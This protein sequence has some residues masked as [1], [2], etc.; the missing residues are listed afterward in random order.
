MIYS[1][2]TNNG[3]LIQCNSRTALKGYILDRYEGYSLETRCANVFRSNITLLSF[4]CDYYINKEE[5]AYLIN[6]Y[7]RL[8]NPFGFNINGSYA[9]LVDWR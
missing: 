2:W 7:K 8:Y 4:G 9:Q 3:K 5:S 1:L 6:V